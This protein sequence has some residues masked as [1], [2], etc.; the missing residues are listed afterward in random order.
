MNNRIFGIRTLSLIAAVAGMSSANA[1]VSI[2]LVEQGSDVL[3]VG[4]GSLDLT[5]LATAGSAVTDAGTDPQDGQ[6]QAGASPN[7]LLPVDFYL[8]GPTYAAPANYGTGLNTTPTAGVGDR[9]T[10]SPTLIGVPSGYTSGSTL[11]FS[12][13]FAGQTLATL[14]ANPGTYTWSWGSASSLIASDGIV[15]TVGAPGS[16]I[17]NARDVTASST[18]GGAQ[19]VNNLINNSGLSTPVTSGQ[20]LTSATAATHD[21][22]DGAITMWV[23]SQNQNNEVAGETLTFDLGLSRDVEGALI[24]QYNQTSSSFDLTNRG[25][26]DFTVAISD[27]N[28]NFTDLGQT[29]SLTEAPGDKIDEFLITPEVIDFGQQVQARYI[30]FTVES[31]FGGDLVGLSEVRFFN[32]AVVPEPTSLAL[33]SLGGIGLIRRRRA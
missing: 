12:N 6:L 24:W 3:L 11:S 33:L 30:R 23:S 20:T 2:F 25:V 32:E 8:G 21:N 17:I 31:N 19:S 4:N 22:N 28:V 13:T 1:S 7:S 18:F 9:F 15:F 27:D 10:L 5:G 29:F 14:G 16:T 26:Q